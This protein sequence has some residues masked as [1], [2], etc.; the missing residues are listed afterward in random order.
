MDHLIVFV[1]EKFSHRV[2]YG[3]I[4]E[5]NRQ[6]KYTYSKIWRRNKNENI[7]AC[8]V[9]SENTPKKKRKKKDY[10]SANR[11]I[12]DGRTRDAHNIM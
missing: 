12:V 5:T 3:K 6:K 2:A 9:F 7:S 8:F 11:H 4:G 10:N 1:A